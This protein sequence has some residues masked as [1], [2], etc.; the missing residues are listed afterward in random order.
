MSRGA[1]IV[2]ARAPRPGEVKTRMLPALSPRQAAEFYA[3]LLADALA[4]TGGWARELALAPVVSVHPPEA[5][6]EV[7]RLAPAGFRAVAQRGADLAERMDWAAR[8]AAAA[9]AAPVMLRGSDSPAL[10]VAIARAALAALE[11]VDVAL[12][13]DRDGG[14][15]LVALRRPASGLF[16]HPMSTHTVL[17][18]TLARA[19]ERGLSARVLPASFDLDVIEDLRWLAEARPALDAELCPRTLAYLDAGDLWR[20]AGPA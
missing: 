20:L 1:V 3:A 15:S 16:S 7:A 11:Q 17:Q 18:D 12:C 19:A 6:A 8:E 10:D 4:A 5:R 13:P 2:F 14:Y 9:G